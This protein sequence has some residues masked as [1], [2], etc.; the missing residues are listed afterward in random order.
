[1]RVRW[2]AICALILAITICI[3]CSSGPA[4]PEKGTP[5]FYWQ[6]AKETF[7]TGDTTKTLEHLDKLLADHNEYSDRAL[8]WSLV[9]T[10][11]L[12]AGYT[13]LADTY[14][15]GGHVNKSDP[16]AFR[17][18][19]M[20][21]RSLAGRLSLQ[22]AENFSKF[23]AVKGDTVPL[24]FGRPIGSAAP[25][26]GLTRIAKGM[27]MPAAD[28]E[29]TEKKTLERNVLLA[30]CA[31]AG[32]PDDTAKMESLLKSPDATVPRPVFVMAM[33]QALYNASQ[34]YTNRKLDDPS[35]LTIFAERAQEAMKA[36]PESKDAKEL[37]AKIAATLKKNKKT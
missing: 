24:A 10:S 6:A 32:A 16:S 18:P 8:A 13:E 17:R 23:A 12:A 20:N 33:A 19:M 25:A 34:L 7:A 2:F 28:L 35:K 22:F 9:L 36:V 29:N 11:G 3:S 31:A 14:E 37:N 1:M 5:A 15:L 26:P 21:D 27:V 4:G 30:A